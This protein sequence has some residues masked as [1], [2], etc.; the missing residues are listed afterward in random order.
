MHTFRTLTLAQD[1]SGGHAPSAR[2][3]QLSFAL[4]RDKVFKKCE[5]QKQ[6]QV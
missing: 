1:L 4:F 3:S 5:I 2:G 6:H